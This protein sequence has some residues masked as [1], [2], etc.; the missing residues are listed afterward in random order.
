MSHALFAPSAA[1][2][3][4]HCPGSVA[5]NADRVDT[6]SVFAR[7]G[8]FAHAIAARALDSGGSAFDY[9]G[10]T[11]KS[12]PD[13]VA[14]GS[15][16]VADGLIWSDEDAEQLQVYL[17]Y[18]RDLML[19]CDDHAIEKRVRV[20]D[21]VYGTA[22]LLLWDGDTLHVVDLKWGRGVRVTAEDNPQLAVYALGASM[23]P[24]RPPYSKVRA[25]IVQPRVAGGV[26]SWDTTRADLMAWHL[27]TVQ[28]AVVAGLEPDAP[29]A[30][31]DWCQFCAAAGTCPAVRQQALAVAQSTFAD[32]GT[33]EPP[34]PA[35]LS[36]QA[37]GDL[38]NRLP[39]LDDW[40]TSVR[41]YAHRQAEAGVTPAGWKL[42]QKI[43]NRD[44]LDDAAAEHALRE[45][46]VDPM[47]RKLVSPAQAEKLLGPALKRIVQPL[48][49][50]P[51]RG[52]ALA[53]SSDPRPA[54]ASAFKA[55]DT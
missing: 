4:L 33:S 45:R 12:F 38:L 23:D 46:G 16:L 48:T 51:L 24:D 5:A 26:T 52:T 34:D 43:G 25:H 8:T 36:P 50:R 20:D 41:A 42:V 29:R 39:M 15:L 19:L 21:H 53:P 2:R 35:T 47:V 28:P 6:G 54:M 13:L 3:W 11:A 44:W 32:L 14:D 10:D 30:A 37:L 49:T 18:V 27:T 17:D 31:G 9:I 55:L 7:E 1:H 22:D 40:I